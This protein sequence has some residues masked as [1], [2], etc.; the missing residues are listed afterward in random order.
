MYVANTTYVR[1]YV[2]NSS[3]ALGFE[4]RSFFNAIISHI[5]CGRVVGG[6]GWEAVDR[7]KQAFKHKQ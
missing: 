3:H 7:L 2:A 4:V 1:T 6:G 5:G